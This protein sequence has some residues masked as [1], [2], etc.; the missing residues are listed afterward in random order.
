MGL[1][2]SHSPVPRPVLALVPE[3]EAITWDFGLLAWPARLRVTHWSSTPTWIFNQMVSLRVSR[4]GSSPNTHPVTLYT[5]GEWRVWDCK[6]VI[7]INQ[8][9]RTPKYP[10]AECSLH[11]FCKEFLDLF[12]RQLLLSWFQIACDS[13]TRQ[14]FFVLLLLRA[15]LGGTSG[16][17]LACQCRRHRFDLWVRKITWGRKRQPTPVFLPGKSHGQRRLVGY[18]P[19]GHKELDTTERLTQ[20]HTKNLSKKRRIRWKKTG[21]M[22]IIVKARG[23]VHESSLY[24]SFYF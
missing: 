3:A 20:T 22:L 13:G 2:I 19:W 7:L 24:S 17:E 15:F 10:S 23:R 16:K 14:F 11:R 4:L 9:A 8:I 18:S 1:K 21:K 5:W 12:C 6:N